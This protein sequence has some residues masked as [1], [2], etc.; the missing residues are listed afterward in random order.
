MTGRVLGVDLGTKRIGVAACDAGRRIASPLLVLM[1]TGSPQQDHRRLAELVK[2]EEI[3]LVI[4]G[5]P[6]DLGGREGIAAQA[7]VAEARALA[8]VVGVPVVTHDERLTTAVAHKALSASGLNGRQR[9]QVVDKWAAA[10]LLQGWLD[11]QT[12]GA[13]PTIEAMQ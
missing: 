10:V 4:V 12:T 11:A 8:T 5:L 3:V 9:R 13:Q 1:R 2:D 6:I 7:A